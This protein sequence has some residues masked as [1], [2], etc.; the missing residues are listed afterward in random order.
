MEKY[1]TLDAKVRLSK[2]R[3]WIACR[4]KNYDYYGIE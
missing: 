2:Q 1:W 4:R 3:V